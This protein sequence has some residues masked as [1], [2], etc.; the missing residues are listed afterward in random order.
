MKIE[1][2]MLA[3]GRVGN[4]VA[5]MAEGG[6]LGAKIGFGGGGAGAGDPENS[7]D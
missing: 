6:A 1:E 4:Q 2:K 3:I 5:R 7:T